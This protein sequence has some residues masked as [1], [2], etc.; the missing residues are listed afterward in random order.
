MYNGLEDVCKTAGYFASPMFQL[1][2]DLEISPVNSIFEEHSRKEIDHCASLKVAR[3][4]P[5]QLD[6]EL[7][8]ICMRDSL[9][10][11]SA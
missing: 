2:E 8:E 4:Q 6:H 11:P 3:I 1:K 10:R 5:K 7:L 9:I